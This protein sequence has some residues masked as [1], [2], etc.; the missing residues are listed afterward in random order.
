VGQRA[1]GQAGHRRL[2]QY[3][4]QCLSAVAAV[5]DYRSALSWI[6]RSD[7]F[8]VHPEVLYNNLAVAELG[9]ERTDTA[10]SEVAKAL[11]FDPMNP[12]F[13]M[14]AGFIADRAGK[15]DDAANY[16]RRALLSDPGAFPAANDLG[17]ELARLHDDVAAEAAQRQ[18]VGAAPNYALGWF[19]LGVLE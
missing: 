17:V 5:D 1:G 12:I 3:G 15:T 7:E 4:R 6:E 16:D 2:E 10:A 9:L 13:L 18:A 11:R 19:N 14:T 8:A